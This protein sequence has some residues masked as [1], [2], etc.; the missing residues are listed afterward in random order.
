MGK[1]Y[2]SGN[3]ASH[4]YIQNLDMH[5]VTPP[6]M[7]NFNQNCLLAICDGILESTQREIITLPP[8]NPNPQANQKYFW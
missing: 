8:Y 1:K 4:M 7:Q 5:I 2:I 3:I 6:C